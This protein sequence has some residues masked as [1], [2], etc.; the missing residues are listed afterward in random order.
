MAMDEQVGTLSAEPE[1]A[2]GQ[3]L[4]QARKA[5][6]LTQQ[7]LCQRANLSYSTLAKIERGAIKAPSIFTIQNIASVLGLTLDE[8]A[9]I[10]SVSAMPPQAGQPAMRSKNGI[11]FVYFDVNNCLIRFWQQAFSRIAE[12][13]GISVDVV[14]ATF[15]DYDDQACRGQL[16]PD[17]F[18]KVLAERL[19]V[20][21][22]NWGKYFI[23]AIQPM[24]GMADLL[25]WV[26]QN[27]KVGLLTNMSGGLIDEMRAKQLV[28]AVDYSAIIWSAQVGTVKPEPAIYDIA[29][30]KAGVSDNEILFIDDSQAFLN[31]AEQRGWRVLRFDNFDPETSIAKIR[32]FLELT[33]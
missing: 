4:Q 11:K 7:A 1:L 16:S 3:R 22:I 31:P 14:E 9:G 13:T 25:S 21:E 20:P 29:A 32:Q 18:N 26:S 28:P 33:D 23:E 2:L 24:P 15:W 10:S 30:A 12:D 5:A 6:G 8:L 27:Y 17:D 19:G